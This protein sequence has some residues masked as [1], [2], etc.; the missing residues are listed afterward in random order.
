MKKIYLVLAASVFMFSSFMHLN[1]QCTGS[2]FH[3]FVFPSPPT[4]TSNIIYGYNKTVYGVPQFLLL[5]IYEPNGDVA[6]NR[7]LLIMAHGGVFV[8]GSKTGTD[9]INM[10]KDFAR[11]GYV[12]ASMQYRL[13]ISGI[14]LPGPDTSDVAETIFRATHDARAAVRFFRKN[15]DVGGNTYDIDT[16]TIF[17]AGVS[18]GG[19]IALHLAYW[20]K[21]S[22]LPSYIDTVGQYGLGGGIEGNSGNPGYSS[23]VKA[24]ISIS[25]AIIDTSWMQPGDEPVLNFH[26]DNDNTVPYGTDTVLI[27][28]L[29]PAIVVDGSHSVAARADHLGIL[30]C[31]ETYEGQEHIPHHND[32]IHYYDSTLVIMRNFLEHFTCNVPLYCNYT[33][34]P[35]LSINSNFQEKNIS[36]YPNPAKHAVLVDLTAFEGNAVSIELYDPLGRAMKNMS[37]IKANQYILN[38]EN[39]P[40]GIYFMNVI[41]EGAR[42]HKKIIFE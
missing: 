12:V 40:S 37:H 35:L 42:A 19:F 34:S 36:V 15:A 17:F 22:E 13:G 29:Y 41:S 38:R 20:D 26:G 1:A 3:D 10:C 32:S 9:V 28:N 30:N 18:S 24:V 8:A 16:N 5:D 21:N 14:P 25:G 27:K 31:F 39:L 4:V 23:E 7:P 2:R 11:M 33:S 6:T